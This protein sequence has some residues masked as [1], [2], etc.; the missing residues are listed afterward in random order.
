MV[1]NKIDF[2]PRSRYWNKDKECMSRDKL[3]NEQLERLKET[4]KR[5]Y[6][7]VTH[8]RNSLDNL[9]VA[10]SD[11][12]KLEDI[13]KLP[14]TTKDDLRQD[15]PFGFFAVPQRDVVRVH[16]S[17]G[18]TG[19]PTVVGY[20]Q[21]DLDVWSELVARVVYAAGVREEDMVQVSFGYGLFTGALGLHYGLEKLGAS[22]VPISS[23]NTERQ[24]M[25]M[26][27]FDTTVLV[28]T[29]S[30]A[31]YM[32]EV[33]ADMGID[34]RSLSV[35]IGLFG[36]E[37]W[38]DEMRN[39]IE[40][41]W[42][43]FA[44][45]N[46]GLSEVMGP[47]VSG[48]C[49]AREGMHVAEDH[50]LVETIDPETLDPLDYGEEGELVITTLTREAMPVIRYRTKDITTLNP[51]PCECGR[52][53]VRMAK[54]SGRTDD[55]LIVRGVNVFPSQIE[56]VLME[57]E[58]TTPHYQIVITRE[59]YLDNI[60]I[61]VELPEEKFTDKFRELE[62]MEEKIQQRLFSVLSINTKVRLVEPHTLQR[63]EGKAKRIIDKRDK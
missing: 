21:K 32:G 5:V 38:T 27:D 57:M 43:C 36:S 45:D 31:L 56:S 14:F 62:K 9:G 12:K 11:I 10:P 20:T 55:M 51:Q 47:G 15:Y 2:I 39:K 35:R 13:R 4:V 42:N 48:E 6:E 41:I 22:V 24:I 7:N 33:A 16:A 34:P 8:Y 58:E 19:K 61:K 17:S 40:K 37:G 49:E 53:S 50:F 18:T 52:T 46:Y 28:S 29:P 3:E 59:G 25:L 1:K 54:V 26:R 30:Y 44:T 23:G 63:F 60:E